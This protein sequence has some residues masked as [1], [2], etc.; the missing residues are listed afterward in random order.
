MQNKY[1]GLGVHVRNISSH[2]WCADNIV[3]TELSNVWHPAF[4]STGTV[5]C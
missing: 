4:A 1:L 5:R 3:Q 2:A